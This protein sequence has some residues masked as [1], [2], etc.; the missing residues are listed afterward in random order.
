MRPELDTILSINKVIAILRGVDADAL[1]PV[2]QALVDGG[3][4]MMEIT[5][6]QHNPASFYDTAAQI[7]A[8]RKRFAGKAYV[9]AG[10]VMTKEQVDLSAEAGAVFIISP[11]TN[12]QV[13]SYTKKRGMVSIPGA[14]TP[15]EIM[16]AY[17]SGADY[18]KVFPAANLGPAYI[19]SI[20]GPLSHIPLMAV[21][22]IDK[23]NVGAFLAAGVCGVGVGGTLLNKGAIA[24]GDY[25]KL[26]QAAQEL[27]AA[28][29]QI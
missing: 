2:A 26:T 28:T 5:Y 17:N 14:M 3:I 13:I 16:L 4:Q 24:Q 9:G 15:S 6:C 22:G 8:L 20:R 18:V 25:E 11:D 10:T 23:N 1:L 7:E 19:K 27:I 21:G 12:P 29:N